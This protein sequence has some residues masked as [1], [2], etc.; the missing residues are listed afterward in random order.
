MSILS[1]EN[2]NKIKSNHLYKAEPKEGEETWC[3]NWTFYPSKNSDG[4][5]FMVD[6]YYGRSSLQV[7]DENINRF[8]EVFD[9]DKVVRVSDPSVPNYDPEDLYRVATDSGGWTCGRLHWKDRD[10]KMSAKRM[11]R[12]KEEKITSLN[13]EVELLERDIKQIKNGEYFD[14]AKGDIIW[15]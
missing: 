2:Y 14:E 13:R 1:K 12:N 11:I 8:T 4:S 7:T 10:T 9:R 6:T 3:R 15:S 5:V